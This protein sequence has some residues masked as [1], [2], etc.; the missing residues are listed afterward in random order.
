MYTVL[1][2]KIENGNYLV[3]YGSD[4]NS[5]SDLLSSTFKVVYWGTFSARN[6][7][8]FTNELEFT[9]WQN[10]NNLIWNATFQS[11]FLGLFHQIKNPKPHVTVLS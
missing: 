5:D 4:R 8:L 10:P 1:P 11:Q 6:S 3:N 7:E 9:F 2:T